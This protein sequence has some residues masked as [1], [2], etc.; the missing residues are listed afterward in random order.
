MIIGLIIGVFGGYFYANKSPRG[1]FEK[2][3]N[4]QITEENRTEVISLFEENPN[5]IS[6]VSVGWSNVA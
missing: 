6:L 2:I 5:N 4:F 1:N 3:N